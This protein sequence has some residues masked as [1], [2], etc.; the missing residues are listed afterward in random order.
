[1]K[2]SIICPS[3]RPEQLPHLTEMY[4][5]QD[6]KNKEL[7]VITGDGTIGAKRNEACERA[8][9]ELIINFDDDDYY[10]S[11]YVSRCVSF[12]ANS[13][14]NVSGLSTAY[15]YQKER[16]RAWKYEYRGAQSY[17]I[18]SGM[19][20]YRHVWERNKFKDVNMG[21]DTYW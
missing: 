1:M 2:V 9:G 3:N 4:H 20:Y 15:F 12:M 16:Q 11:D 10:T 14:A 8:K 17:V 18:G 19:C 13:G 7:I 6:Y 21:E 5:R